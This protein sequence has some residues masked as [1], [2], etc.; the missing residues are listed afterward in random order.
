MT[1]KL[2]ICLFFG[3]FLTFTGVSFFLTNRPAVNIV[4][5]ADSKYLPYMMTSLYSAI[6]NKYPDTRYSIH[7]IAQDFSKDD[8]KKLNRMTEEK[9]NIKIYPT[10]KIKLDTS[11]LGRFASFKVALQKLF[12]AGYLKDIEKVLIS[13]RY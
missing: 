7:V 9:V 5:M 10:Q 2:I 11:H 3:M 12:I 4:Y 6:K 8:I 13:E 1:K